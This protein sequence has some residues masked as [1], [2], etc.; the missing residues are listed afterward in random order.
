MHSLVEIHSCLQGIPHFFWKLSDI[1]GP[2]TTKTLP[3]GMIH[4]SKVVECPRFSHL[5]GD[6]NKAYILK[7]RPGV[8]TAN[9]TYLFNV[10]L[11]CVCMMRVVVHV[12][13]RPSTF[14]QVPGTE[15]SA[16]TH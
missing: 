4:I 8:S 15:V 5:G 12:V 14:L 11:P 6:V 7:T 2:G 9:P 10:L 16:L 13:G 1:L 3:F